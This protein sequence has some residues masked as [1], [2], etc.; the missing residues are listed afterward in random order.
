[1]V[2]V[3][4]AE[5]ASPRLFVPLAE[6]VIGLALDAGV[7]A[8]KKA[9]DAPNTASLRSALLSMFTRKDIWAKSE[10]MI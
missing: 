9:I 3:A 2:K 7:N 5:I 1:V 4:D 8:T 10:S 6:N